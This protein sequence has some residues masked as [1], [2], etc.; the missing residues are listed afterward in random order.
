VAN[1]II[2]TIEIIDKLIVLFKDKNVDATIAGI[3][4]KIIKGFVTPPVK[5]SNKDN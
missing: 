2:I 3:I 5:Y 1:K 4:S